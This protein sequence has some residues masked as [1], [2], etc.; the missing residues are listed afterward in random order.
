MA[1]LLMIGGLAPWDGVLAELVAAERRGEPELMAFAITE[2]DAGTD[3]DDPDL[4]RLGRITAVARRVA[5]GYC[6]TGAKHYISNG[7]VA[8]RRATPSGDA[9][10]E[11]RARPRAADRADAPGARFPPRP[12]RHHPAAAPH[13]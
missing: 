2:P 10:G 6:L 3:V 1:S 8:R 12:R 5:G 4:L 9:A 7:S 13:D 11:R